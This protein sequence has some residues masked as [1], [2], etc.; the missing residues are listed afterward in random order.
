M[1]TVLSALDYLTEIVVP[2]HQLLGVKRMLEPRGLG[3]VEYGDVLW[4]RPPG[5]PPM[6]RIAKLGMDLDPLPGVVWNRVSVRA[7]RHALRY[8][9]AALAARMGVTHRAVNTWEDDGDTAPG[10]LSREGLDTLYIRLTPEQRE[11]FAGYVLAEV[12]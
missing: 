5:A 11:R 1:T 12:S 8:T 7:L 9:T 4:Y 10:P 6:L 3:L 2:P